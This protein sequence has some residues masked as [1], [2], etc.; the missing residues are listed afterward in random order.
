[1]EVLRRL[2]AI[3]RYLDRLRA[4]DNGAGN[5]LTYTPT[6]DGAV[7]GSTTNTVQQG[8]YVVLGKK[9]IC[10]GTI[11]WTAASGTGAARIS[12]PFT[13]ANTS[14]QNFGGTAWL[15]G[16]TFANGTP[17]VLISPNTAYFS[18][19]SPLTNAAN[20]TVAVEAAGTIVWTVVFFTA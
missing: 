5:P 2:D 3:E 20:T 9:V 10:T 7:S 17:L 18:L 14:N 1:M 12:L 13:A 8:S 4:R 6:Y 15:S 16:G 11:A 19:F